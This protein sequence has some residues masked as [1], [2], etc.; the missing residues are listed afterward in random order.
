MR[1]PAPRVA[2]VALIVALLAGGLA[3]V[4]IRAGEGGS[5][6]A[7]RGTPTTSP[8]PTATFAPVTSTT[9]APAP[10]TTQ[11]VPSALAAT[12]AQIQAQVAQVRGLQW[13]GPLDISVA[14]DAEFVRQLNAVTQRD[15]HPDRIRGDEET[16]K[17][18]KLIPQ[19]TDYL[20]AYLGLLGGAVLGFYDPKTGKLLV[21]A[22]GVLTPYQRITI[23]HEM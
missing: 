1:V 23:A 14:P 8:S 18:L 12:F 16:Y 4:V 10:A 2:L 9:A 11:P 22:N 19:N 20:K 5:K 15:L 3:A 13:L 6:V 21:R 17:L 7:S